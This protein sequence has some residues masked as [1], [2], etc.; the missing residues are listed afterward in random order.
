METWY[1]FKR[2]HLANCWYVGEYAHLTSIQH[3]AQ[4]L[5]DRANDKFSAKTAKTGA[6]QSSLL[7]GNFS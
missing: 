5:G 3:P 4:N 7:H 6:S 2:M 1:N